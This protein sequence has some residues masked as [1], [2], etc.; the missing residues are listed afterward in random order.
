MKK[1][2]LILLLFGLH[3]ALLFA[4][5]DMPPGGPGGPGMQSPKER[6]K[7]L[8]SKLKL[9]DDQAAKIETIFTK[10]QK[11]MQSMFEN[12][13]GGGNFETMRKTMDAVQDSSTAAINKILTAEQKP[14]YKKILDDRKKEMEKMGPPPD[15]QAMRKGKHNNL[16]TV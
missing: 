15:G 7:N 13:D 2:L 10:E 3:S 11:K 9:T 4:Q 12:R 1:L 6:V 16:R 8:I 14:L 5:D